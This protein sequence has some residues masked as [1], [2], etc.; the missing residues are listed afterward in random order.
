MP[1]AAQDPILRELQAIHGI[2]EDLL[3]LECARTGMKR[4]DLRAVVPVGNNR[5]SRIARHVKMTGKD[6]G[7]D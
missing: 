4:A 5:I 7:D 3:I 1:K 6:L 2:L